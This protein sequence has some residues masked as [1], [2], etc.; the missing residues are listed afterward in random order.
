MP[1]H[2][3]KFIT[4]LFACFS[5][6][7]QAEGLIYVATQDT[8]N[9]QELYFVVVT[10]SGGVNASLP[11]KL[12]GPQPTG[13][14]VAFGIPVFG[15][16]GDIF[17]GANEDDATKMELYIV[18]IS[19]PGA[20]TKINA[21]LTADQ[22]IELGLPCSGGTRVFYTL[23]TISTDTVDLYV[24]TV[25]NPGVA[26]KL[27]PV[28][29]AGRKVGEFIVTPDCTQV[30][31]GAQLN[32]D[33]EELFVTDINTP[34][35][36]TKADGPPAGADH[37]IEQLSLSLDG[38]KAFWIGGR[39]QIGLVK[40]LMTV[41]LNNL[42]NDIQV[43]EDISSGEQI[44][45]FEVSPDAN[46]VVYRLDVSALETSDVFVVDLSSNSSA[47]MLRSVRKPG[48]ADQVNPD[49]LS[50]GFAPFGGFESIVM[51]DDGTVVMYNGPLDD[52]NVNELYE[53]ALNNLQ[54]STKL[55][56][57]LGTPG[58]GAP[59]GVS[60]FLRSPDGSMVVYSDGIG[61]TSGINVVDRSNPGSAVQPFLPGVNQ[62]SGLFATI[63]N[64]SD[65][66]A[67]IITNVD[68]MGVPVNGELHVGRTTVDSSNVRVSTDLAAGFGVLF[69]FWIPPIA[70]DA[71]GDGIPDGEDEFP[72]DPTEATDTDGDG[73]GNNADPDDDNDGIPDGAD[74][75]PLG[76]FTDV[77]P[78]THWAFN[79]IERL[80]RAGVTSGCGNGNYCP[81][82]PVTRAQMA[83]FLERGMR[84]GDFSPPAATGNVFLDVGAGDFAAS[85]IE[86][87]FADGITAGCGNNNYCP[88]PTVTRDQMAVFL[89]RAK[90]GS[91][92]SPP[93]ATGIF[94]DVDLSYW[95]VA[96]IEQLAAEGITS[97]CGGGNYCPS[98]VVT[99]DQMAV[100][101]VRTFGL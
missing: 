45:H 37:V 7:V 67:S 13:G 69:S 70:G 24:V 73:I 43:N 78:A 6:Y 29:S 61:G 38:T 56:D 85:F 9:L 16:P 55:N 36:A 101:L 83:V 51:V 26:T 86:Q 94:G 77:P 98:A 57:S 58:M 1:R 81:D 76:Q 95:A 53:T 41:T 35:M 72:N 93:P 5:S 64:G 87:L 91:S 60:L 30:I 82:D 75:F 49:W 17:Y 99:R 20:S 10:G 62:Q 97:G 88:D 84:G 25:S 3:L 71:D 66:I 22:E 44:L 47:M 27:N 39:R 96:W 23:R 2:F 34:G 11:I 19:T 92:Y 8:D 59:A 12:S 89:L 65:L 32:S 18:A 52:A 48:T 4:I 40:N 100:F 54:T 46:T 28:L 21:D 80:A 31:Y 68:V 50:G 15:S 90:H 74:E 42:G 14:G 79:F 63:N 33:A